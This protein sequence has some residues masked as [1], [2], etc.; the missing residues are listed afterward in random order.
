MNTKVSLN[1]LREHSPP[2]ARESFP[3][4]YSQ[5]DAP[6][7]KSKLTQRRCQ[8]SFQ[9][10]K[11]KDMWPPP[12]SILSPMSFAIW[13]I[14]KADACATSQSS[15][16]VMKQA[17]ETAWCNMSEDAHAALVPV[18]DGANGGRGGG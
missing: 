11:G 4:G 3:N 1:L 15:T 5:D 17:L 6:L 13:S 7:H 2:C 16:A 10:F 18:S 9:R 8:S 12:S 14:L